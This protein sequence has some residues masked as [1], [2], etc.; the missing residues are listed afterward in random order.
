[1]TQDVE[2]KRYCVQLL[3]EFGSIEYTRQACINLGKQVFDE[4]HALGGNSY[5]ENI[6]QSLVEIFHNDSDSGNEQDMENND[7]YPAN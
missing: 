7:K 5:L 6:V 4:I 1:R 2:L 3:H